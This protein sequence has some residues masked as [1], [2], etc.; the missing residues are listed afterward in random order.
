MDLPPCLNSFIPDPLCRKLGQ[1]FEA[2]PFNPWD[3]YVLPDSE[4][5]VDFEHSPFVGPL[6]KLDSCILE[7]EE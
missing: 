6:V 3:V 1:F 7:S 4:D 5:V 2:T